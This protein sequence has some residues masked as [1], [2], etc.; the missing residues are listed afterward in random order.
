MI[1]P[2]TSPTPGFEGCG[3]ADVTGPDDEGLYDC[4]NCGLWFPAV[5]EEV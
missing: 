5:S 4:H 2:V 1:C 3:S